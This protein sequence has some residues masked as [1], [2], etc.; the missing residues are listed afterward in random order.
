[1]QAMDTRINA[2]QAKQQASKHSPIQSN[3][4]VDTKASLAKIAN[5]ASNLKAERIDSKVS[6]PLNPVDLLMRASQ[7]TFA[8]ES[9]YEA[10]L[11][12]KE[13]LSKTTQDPVIIASLDKEVSRGEQQIQFWQGRE[14]FWW[15]ETKMATPPK[16]S[17]EFKLTNEL[18]EGIA[19]LENKVGD[20]LF[21][22]SPYAGIE[23]H[24][25]DLVSSNF[26]NGNLKDAMKFLSAN[27]KDLTDIKPLAFD[28]GTVPEPEGQAQITSEKS[29]KYKQASA[30]ISKKL[31]LTTDPKAKAQLKNQFESQKELSLFFGARSKVWNNEQYRSELSSNDPRKDKIDYI[32][33]YIANAEAKFENIASNPKQSKT[34]ILNKKKLNSNLNEISTLLGSK[35]GMSNNPKILDRVM[36][37]IKNNPL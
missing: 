35:E 3:S 24:Q 6:K 18:R 36:K 19:K 10:A 26:S 9:Y 21:N 7:N 22:G 2:L 1:M 5:L 31:S 33:E 37:L 8:G 15:Q 17:P 34:D 28:A 4:P 32:R 20:S 16:D 29:S 14:D 11:K 23:K 27:P 12:K 13:D 25:L 30:D